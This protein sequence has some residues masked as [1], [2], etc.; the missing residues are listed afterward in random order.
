MQKIVN[1]IKNPKYLIAALCV[2][3]AISLFISLIDITLAALRYG[4]AMSTYPTNGTFQLYNPLLRIADGQIA[5]HD[6]PFF[7]GVGVPYLHFPTFWLLGQNVFAAETSKFFVNFFVFMIVAWVFFYAFFRDHKKAIIGAAVVCAVAPYVAVDTYYPG[8]AVLGIRT[9]F[10]MLVA[11]AVLWQTTHKLQ[12]TKQLALAYNDIAALILLG[13]AFQFGTEQGLAAIASYFLIKLF[14]VYKA[15]QKKLALIHFSVLLVLGAFITLLLLAIT[16]RGH[17]VDVLTYALISI[18]GDQGW[19]FGVPPNYYLSIEAIQAV[20]LGREALVLYS[21]IITGLVFWCI[22]YK[23]KLLTSNQLQ[24]AIFLTAYGTIVFA[25]SATGYYAPTAHVIPLH[26]GMLLISVAIA[27]V[28]GLALMRQKRAWYIGLIILASLGAMIT[29]DI[30][31]RTTAVS[32]NDVKALLNTAKQARHKDDYY[33][34]SPHWLDATNSFLPLIPKD[35]TLWSTYTSVYDSLHGSVN[36]SKGGEDYIIHALGD[37]RRN[38]YNQQFIRDK[39]DYVI[40]MRPSF[41]SYEEWLWSGHWEFYK[42]LFTKYELIAHNRSHV[43][44]KI[45]PDAPVATTP[46]QSAIKTGANTFSL[47]NNTSDRPVLYEV[48]VNY[49]ASAN[50]GLKQFDRLGRYFV[51]IKNT[52]VM[53]CPVSLPPNKTSWSFAV[54]VAPQQQN[55]TVSTRTPG[56]VNTASLNIHSFTYR[57]LPI[58]PKND[59]EFIDNKSSNPPSPPKAF[60]CTN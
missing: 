21:G 48:S 1:F 34:L 13:L 50:L 7:H 31:D 30:R 28:F 10:P 47:P 5:G 14:F 16:T 56:V 57:Q 24:A 22:A 18:P 49:T 41:F 32:K 12:I 26:R 40:T 51:D 23:K 52:Q 20:T 42:Q 36:P 6:F 35:A 29:L 54:A 2:L 44:W 59:F 9:A 39:P 38:D 17:I 46:F 4:T 45:K 25:V 58:D 27:I 53:H 19:Y 55:I 43:L 11:A 37:K 60:N 15:K 33:V 3:G 8:N